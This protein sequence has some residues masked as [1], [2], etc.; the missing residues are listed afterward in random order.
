VKHPA[1]LEVT[2]PVF[3]TI[4][5]TRNFI[6]NSCVVLG[7]GEFEQLTHVAKHRAD[8]FEIGDDAFERRAFLAERLR[9]LRLVPYRRLRQFEFYF[10]EAVLA[11]GEVKGTP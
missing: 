6:E 8:L 5:F 4:E 7:G 11:V 9:A 10:L 2:Q 3:D 1:K